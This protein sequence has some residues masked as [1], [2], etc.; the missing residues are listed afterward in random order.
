MEAG[1]TREFILKVTKMEKKKESKWS[2][3][4]SVVESYYDIQSQ[5]IMVENRL[6]ALEQGVSPQLEEFMQ[7]QVLVGLKG[8]EKDIKGQLK[9]YLEDRSVYTEYLEGIKGIGVVLA[10]GLI[11]YIEDPGKFATISKLWRYSGLAVGEDGRAERREKGKKLH[12]NPRMKVLCWKIGES[13]VKVGGGYRDLYDKFREDY[14]KKWITS[15]DCGSI[16][17]KKAGKGKCMDG[18]RY[19]AAKRKAVKVFLAHLHQEWSRM[20][21][22]KVT[23]PFIIGRMGHSHEIPI[24]RT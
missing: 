16:G 13:F 2:I 24:I 10:A 19:A 11:G 14:D 5:R 3:L 18:H 22:S 17:C 4:R 15:A 20:K 21:G 12:F 1:S 6:R 7:E 9:I 8:I 23:R